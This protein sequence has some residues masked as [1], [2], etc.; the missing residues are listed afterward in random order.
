MLCATAG[1]VN[2]FWGVL[3]ESVAIDVY[4]GILPPIA[5]KSGLEAQLVHIM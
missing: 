1:K 5:V 3:V 4:L 2:S